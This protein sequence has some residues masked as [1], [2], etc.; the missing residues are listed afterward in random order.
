MTAGILK[1]RLDLLMIKGK[2]PLAKGVL[3]T[4]HEDND[5]G[6]VPRQNEFVSSGERETPVHSIRAL[7]RGLREFFFSFF[8]PEAPPGK[9]WASQRSRQRAMIPK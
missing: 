9:I 4:A 6:K 5:I 7:S 2:F 3:L 1:I 8:F